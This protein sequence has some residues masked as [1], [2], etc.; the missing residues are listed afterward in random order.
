MTSTKTRAL[1]I[2][3]ITAVVLA[4]V[5]FVFPIR[6]FDGEIHVV[7]Q[8]QDYTIDTQMSLSYFIGIGLDEADMKG[9]ESF[10]LTGKGWAMVAIFILGIPALLAYRI[11]LK[12]KG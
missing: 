1:A 7:N 4:I 8:L 5:F 6:I 9:V 12:Y 10:R 2:F 11:Y 3:V